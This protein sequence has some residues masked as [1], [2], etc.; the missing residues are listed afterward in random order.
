MGTAGPFTNITQQNLG[1]FRE[2]MHVPDECKR[3][4]DHVVLV[5]NAREFIDRFISAVKRENY[6]SEGRLVSY[7]DPQKSFRD[8]SCPI[9]AKQC[10]YVWQREYRCVVFTNAARGKP[11]ILDVGDL[12]DICKIVSS[13]SINVDAHVQ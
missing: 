1:A 7:Y 9:F 12:N 2:H 10:R 3:M 5:H 11:L 6:K 4:G 8:I 13:G